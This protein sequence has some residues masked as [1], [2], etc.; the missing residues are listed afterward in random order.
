M[1]KA[2]FV[3]SS[4]TPV[5]RFGAGFK[6]FNFDYMSIIKIQ[7]EEQVYG[8][9]VNIITNDVDSEIANG[10]FQAVCEVNGIPADWAGQIQERL[11][12]G[13]IFSNG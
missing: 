2:E 7:G 10:P 6:R 5:D 4:T 8:V 12:D 3:D 11:S 9:P 1:F 13:V